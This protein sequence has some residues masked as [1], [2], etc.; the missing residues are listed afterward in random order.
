MVDTEGKIVEQLADKIIEKMEPFVRETVSK[1]VQEEVVKALRKAVADSNFYRG[2]SDDVVSGVERI[3]L[4]IASAKR[5]VTSLHPIESTVHTLGESQS[6]L[7]NILNITETSTL[8]IM[9]IVELIQDRLREVKAAIE[10]TPDAQTPLDE[11]DAA[12]LEVITLLSFQDITGQK[13][14]KLIDSLRKAEEIAFEIYLS[15]EAF[16]KVK[17]EGFDKDYDQLRDEVKK[18]VQSL[19]AKREEVIDQSAIDTMLE[20][21][22]LR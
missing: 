21:L 13:I 20:S 7:D 6:V 14:K 10:D 15:S 1:T 22:S 17:S 5:E 18:Q 4:E 2:L 9:D 11:I 3:Y 12:L 16:K 8:K 19:K